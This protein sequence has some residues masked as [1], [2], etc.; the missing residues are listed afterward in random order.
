[1]K[2][3]ISHSINTD[4]FLTQSDYIQV[5]SLINSLLN[6]NIPS[7]QLDQFLNDEVSVTRLFNEIKLKFSHPVS[8]PCLSGNTKEIQHNSDCHDHNPCSSELKNFGDKDSFHKDPSYSSNNMSSKTLHSPLLMHQNSTN[9]FSQSPILSPPVA[10]S[11][12]SEIQKYLSK[13]SESRDNPKIW[14][15]SISSPTINSLDN[16][17]HSGSPDISSGTVSKNSKSQIKI[18]FDDSTSNGS[19]SPGDTFLPSYF[20]SKTP[21]PNMEDSSS[22]LLDNMNS[23]NNNKK[24]SILQGKIPIQN[25]LSLNQDKTKVHRQKYQNITSSSPKRNLEDPRFDRIWWKN[26]SFTPDLP[27]LTVDSDPKTLKIDAQNSNKAVNLSPEILSKTPP[28]KSV[29][30]NKSVKKSPTSKFNSILKSFEKDP[31]DSSKFLVQDLKHSS[32]SLMIDSIKENL[33]YHKHNSMPINASNKIKDSFKEIGQNQKENQDSNKIPLSATENN[34][35]YNTK[36]HLKKDSSEKPALRPKIKKTS[37]KSIVPETGTVSVSPSLSRNKKKEGQTAYLFDDEK[38]RLTVNFENTN[39]VIQ[40]QIGNCIG[41]GQFG[42]VYRALNLENGQMVAIKQIPTYKQDDG[43]LDEI[44]H[45]VQT[46]KGLSNPRIVRY[47]DFVVHC[48]LKAANILTTKKGN[49]KLAD[50][51]VSLNLGLMHS[52]DESMVVAGTPCWMA[53][54]IIK[55]EG[56]ST[57]SDI[58]SLGCTIVELLSGKPPYS[59]LVSMAALYHIV[60]D[61]HP[62]FPENISSEMKNLRRNY[63][64]RMSRVM[65][66]EQTP[67][68]G[69]QLNLLFLRATRELETAESLDSALHMSAKSLS[70]GENLISSNSIKEFKVF[71][72]ESPDTPLFDENNEDSG[73]NSSE[74][75]IKSLTLLKNEDGSLESD[76]TDLISQF[77]DLSTSGKRYLSIQKVESENTVV[78][79]PNLKPHNMRIIISNDLNRVCFVCNEIINGFCLSCIVCKSSCHKSCDRNSGPCTPITTARAMIPPNRK[80]SKRF[81][82]KLLKVSLKEK[83]S[84]ADNSPPTYISTTTQSTQY[85]SSNPDFFEQS[86]T[87][88]I[89]SNSSIP[90]PNHTD[91]SKSNSSIGKVDS[92][93]ESG[94]ISDLRAHRNSTFNG[95][96]SSLDT[97]SSFR[98]RETDLNAASTPQIRRKK[99]P[100]IPGSMKKSPQSQTSS[101]RNS[102]HSDGFNHEFDFQIYNENLVSVKGD[103]SK[104]LHRSNSFK[105]SSQIVDHK[106][107]HNGSFLNSGAFEYSGMKNTDEGGS[108]KSDSRP[109]SWLSPKQLI[110]EISTPKK[111]GVFIDYS[112]KFRRNRIPTLTQNSED[113]LNRNIDRR[114]GINSLYV[115]RVSDPYQD[116]YNSVKTPSH[117]PRKFPIVNSPSP[118]IKPNVNRLSKPRSIS[119]NS[120]HADARLANLIQNKNIIMGSPSLRLKTKTGS[121]QPPVSAFNSNSF[122]RNNYNPINLSKSS[123]NRADSAKRMNNTGSYSSSQGRDRSYSNPSVAS[124]KTDILHSDVVFNQDIIFDPVSLMPQRRMGKNFK[125]SNSRGVS[126]NNYYE[127]DSEDE[128]YGFSSAKGSPST[129][130]GSAMGSS[131]GLNKLRRKV[132]SKI[133]KQDKIHESDVESPN[134]SKSNRKKSTDCIIM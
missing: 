83:R 79:G 71:E 96:V 14:S 89:Y 78:T 61:D 95:T 46:L 70:I 106:D 111:F 32:D 120:F 112:N 8:A 9:H 72:D 39:N 99:L 104:N 60:E 35:I 1:M 62:P 28:K 26:I 75:F 123:L 63:S 12:Y 7:S 40:Y 55:L 18:S 42:S 93:A 84:I 56:P 90:I 15:T 133:F 80:S 131:G 97:H 25:D 130:P 122:G 81:R 19:V 132:S 117:D 43:K 45:E 98:S 22:R 88:K 37:L 66:K 119:D 38:K 20:T 23:T 77:E 82:D 64:M 105:N 57:S 44:M 87:K 92:V 128:S 33:I 50:F 110:S 134:L 58:W 16:F 124:L 115:P 113:S 103:I 17:P 109:N 47:Y 129:R 102:H 114:L 107:P 86:G 59:D 65:K 91:I 68:Q 118:N 11:E 85:G 94:S 101:L 76:P 27:N 13:K 126:S 52:N 31:C 54:E 5:C 49:I 48:D 36:S 4:D 41:K 29:I 74:D 10:L 100:E 127:S 69:S 34:T 125:S 121:Y 67:E 116:S 108:F 24:L 51:G 6:L 30:R 53:P 3:L 21:F 73:G 2:P